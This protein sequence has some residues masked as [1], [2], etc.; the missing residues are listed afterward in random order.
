MSA[1]CWPLT[2]HWP[3]NF[4]RN[5]DGSEVLNSFVSLN[6][7]KKRN[8]EEKHRHRSCQVEW[9]AWLTEDMR[10]AAKERSK[11]EV[12]NSVLV[13]CASILQVYFTWLWLQKEKHAAAMYCIL[14]YYMHLI[15]KTPKKQFLSLTVARN[16]QW[17]L[18]LII[19]MPYRFWYCIV[20]F[21]TSAKNNFIF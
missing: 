18:N 12:S 14:I 20:H 19:Y 13:L 4:K 6:K 9:V 2:G 17:N 11:G 8:L 21:P 3:W 5:V 15:K 7:L 1:A 10:E 16:T